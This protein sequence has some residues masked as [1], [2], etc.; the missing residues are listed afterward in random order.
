MLSKEQ[1]KA[2]KTENVYL[3]MHLGFLKFMSGLKF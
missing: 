2:I 1:S 3:E